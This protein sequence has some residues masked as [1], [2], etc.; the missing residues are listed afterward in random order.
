MIDEK[1]LREIALLDAS[2]GV[3]DAPSVTGLALRKLLGIGEV[4]AKVFASAL[5]YI[6]EAS[7][8]C[9]CGDAR[10]VVLYS[11]LVIPGQ[12]RRLRYGCQCDGPVPE[13]YAPVSA[14]LAQLVTEGA[15]IAAEWTGES[16]LSGEKI[17]ALIAEAR[18]VFDHQVSTWAP[19]LRAG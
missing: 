8:R 3:R 18:E 7:K 15:E 17:E 19:R 2:V 1:K 11:P 5:H 12:Y 10:G 13:G 4:E 6:R 14:L 9:S 16:T